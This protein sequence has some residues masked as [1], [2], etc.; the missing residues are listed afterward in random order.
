M[1]YNHQPENESELGWSFWSDHHGHGGVATRRSRLSEWAQTW[2]IEPRCAHEAW[3]ADTKK[4]NQKR[5]KKAATQQVHSRVQKRVLG[6]MLRYHSPT[7]F[8]SRFQ[9]YQL[10]I[11]WHQFFVGALAACLR[12]QAQCSSEGVHHVGSRTYLSWEFSYSGLSRRY[13]I[14]NV[15]NLHH[16]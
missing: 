13:F 3:L 9:E 4:N 5:N 2:R 6:T 16:W 10:D 7:T 14:Y 8:G 11:L 1:G 12:P 15:I